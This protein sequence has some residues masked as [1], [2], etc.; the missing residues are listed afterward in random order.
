MFVPLCS[1]S[2]FVELLRG[3]RP[4]LHEVVQQQADALPGDGPAFEDHLNAPLHEHVEQRGAVELL[5]TLERPLQGDQGRDYLR[6][7]RMPA[8]TRETPRGNVWI[9]QE[10][11]RSAMSGLRVP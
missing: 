3:Q 7:A 1:C 11:Q 5:D 8:V 9:E 2:P 4:L 6:V 10:L